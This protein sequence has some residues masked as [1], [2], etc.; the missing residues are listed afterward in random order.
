MSN[1]LSKKTERN[2]YD[3][4]D[5]EIPRDPAQEPFLKNLRREELNTIFEFDDFTREEYFQKYPE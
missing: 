3:N 1:F 5:R 2:L 4:D